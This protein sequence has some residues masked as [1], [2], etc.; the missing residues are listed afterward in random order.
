[1]RLLSLGL[2]GER[3]EYEPSNW[4]S[5]KVSVG[6]VGVEG[7]GVEMS[8]GGGREERRSWRKKT[9]RPRWIRCSAVALAASALR[10]SWA[11]SFSSL[12][13][14]IEILWRVPS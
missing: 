12:V 1:M 9:S 5:G 13:R 4:L 8:S 14:R 11:V 7:G 2:G 10:K 3:G 6:G